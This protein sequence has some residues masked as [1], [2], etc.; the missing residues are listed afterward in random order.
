MSRDGEF[1]SPNKSTQFSYQLTE[2]PNKGMMSRKRSSLGTEGVPNK[3][4]LTD[5]EFRDRKFLIF[6]GF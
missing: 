6:I 1:V 3:R 5:A 2:W 4:V